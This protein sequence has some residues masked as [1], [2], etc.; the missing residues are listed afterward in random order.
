MEILACGVTSRVEG[1][2][3]VFGEQH[4]CAW[5]DRRRSKDPLRFLAGYSLTHCVS[6]ERNRQCMGEISLIHLR[7]ER[8]LPIVMREPRLAHHGSA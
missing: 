6:A 3:D 1:L 5:R 4:V 8:L 7:A 2:I